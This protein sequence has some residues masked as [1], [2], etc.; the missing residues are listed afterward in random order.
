MSTEIDSDLEPLRRLAE[1][2]AGNEL[3][4]GLMERDD[5]PCAPFDEKALHKA[6]EVGLLSLLLPEEK[7]GTGQGMRA[8]CRILQSLAQ[9]EAG[10]AAVV[11]V[12]A[13]AHAA[14]VRWGQRNCLDETASS[15]LTGFPAYTLPTDLP[16]TVTAEKVEK[17]FLLSGTLDYVA[18]AP[19]A[20]RLLL[21]ARMKGN[22]QT[23]F[24]LTETGQKGLQVK[25]PVLSLGLRPCPVADVELARVLV[26]ETHMLCNDAEKGYPELAAAFR[27]AVAALSL[28][29]LEG[30]F[31]T[32]QTYAEQ[33]HQ[34]GKMI[35]EHDQIRLMLAGMA[36][37]V[38]AG[39]V[40]VR[41]MAA[42]VDQGNPGTLADAGLILVS[43]QGAE[44]AS[45]GVQILGGYGYSQDYGQEK[46]MRDA[47]QIASFFGGTMAARLDLIDTILG[48]QP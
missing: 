23:A 24:F 3:E 43:G 15:S 4:P 48:K 1:R 32:A 29:V 22:G 42:R 34:G 37:A 13:L 7:G 41:E 2:F 9:V 20:A 46:R 38:E 19:V 45:D 17:G 44:G 11:F 47:K 39:R 5:Y 35:V 16:G 12:N 30:S 6:G 25:E 27:P 21:P 40:L 28:G 14:L 18:L 36:V 31:R 33:R 10:F 26:P 8:L